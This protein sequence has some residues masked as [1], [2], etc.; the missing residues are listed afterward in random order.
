MKCNVIKF[1]ENEINE[2]YVCEI[3]TDYDK[4]SE[5]SE[6]VILKKESIETRSTILKL[7]NTIR[8]NENMV[9]LSA[10]QIGIRK[11]II[12][13]NFNGDIRT[14]INPLITDREGLELTRESCHSIPGKEFIINRNN[15]ISITYTTP[16][17]KIETVQ[18]L[19][20]AAF[21]AQHQVEHLDGILVSD[22]GLEVDE[23]FDQASEEERDEV[24]KMYLDSI[25]IKEKE[26]KMSIEDDEDAKK[27]SD[28]V[29]F[30]KGVESGDVQIEYIPW[31]QEEIDEYEKNKDKED[32]N[33]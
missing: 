5:P 1:N 4:L 20:L 27:L 24:I 25:D 12:C 3:E 7:K 15:K 18:L 2:K 26:I 30:I 6:E 11:R 17:G 9:G 23:L 14:M 28:A 33:N 13:I 16:L 21:I 10:P 8:A 19:G 31:T 32:L 22:L 29:R